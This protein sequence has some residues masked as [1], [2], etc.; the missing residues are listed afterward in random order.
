MP[1]RVDH[2]GTIASEEPLAVN[3]TEFDINDP[4]SGF[5]GANYFESS[6]TT[7]GGDVVYLGACRCSSVRVRSLLLRGHVHWSHNTGLHSL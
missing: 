1:Q 7:A 6:E 4:L 2:V 5:M 3:I